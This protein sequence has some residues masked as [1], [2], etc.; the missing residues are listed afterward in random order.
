MR[1]RGRLRT[2]V[3]SK[4]DAPRPEKA[5]CRRLCMACEGWNERSRRDYNDYYR[6]RVPF[7]GY[8]E[9]L[10]ARSG[11]ALD[12]AYGLSPFRPALSLNMSDQRSKSSSSFDA[13]D[14]EA[15]DALRW[16]AEAP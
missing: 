3:F 13:S 15:L 12:L 9:V 1:R 11:R 5:L 2:N 6:V 14:C 16:R 8:D 10:A 7:I 4:P